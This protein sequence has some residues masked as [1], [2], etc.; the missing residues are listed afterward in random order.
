MKPISCIPELDCARRIKDAGWRVS[1][2]QKRKSY[3]IASRAVSKRVT[4]RHVNFNGL[5]C[6]IFVNTTAVSPH[7]FCAFL[8]V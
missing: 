5:N 3:T 6:V 7:L 2:T 1:I 4:A 8:V